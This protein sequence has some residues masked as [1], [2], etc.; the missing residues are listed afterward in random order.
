MKLP[1]SADALPKDAPSEDMY[2]LA[3][4]IG[5]RALWISSV[6]TP[7]CKFA[8]KSSTQKTDT[9][10]A[11]TH[12]FYE[13]V[14]ILTGDVEFM[15]GDRPFPVA[16]HT[17]VAFPPGLRHGALVKTDRPYE[18]YTLHFD[19][20]CLSMERR[21]LLGEVLPPPV[22]A[23]DPHREETC[24]WKNMN[25]SGVLQCLEAMETLH[26]LGNGKADMLLPI[27]V[28]SV[29]ATLYAVQQIRGHAPHR[30]PQP[31]TTQQDLVLWV[32][33]HYTEPVTLESLSERFFLSKGYVNTLFRQATGSTVKV[34]VLKRR[35]HYVQMLL[36]AGLPTAQAASRAGFDDYT[37]FY[38]AYTRTYGHAPSDAK[39]TASRNEL[40][41]EALSVRSVPGRTLEDQIRY[42][43]NGTETEDPSMRNAIQI[44]A[45]KDPEQRIHT[46]KIPD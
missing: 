10:A 41:A 37:T 18:R 35:M 30:E 36:A 23:A 6:S 8:H 25:H 27:Y 38:R 12:P 16:E 24:L 28:E 44:P 17:L 26:L 9:Y 31:T 39:R 45:G 14:Y 46:R 40:L 15:I 5:S 19:A 13:I 22:P 11:H 20:G 2:A 21:M 7:Q 34:Y 32:E 42:P 29:L 4:G 43:E 1:V 33:Q 3:P